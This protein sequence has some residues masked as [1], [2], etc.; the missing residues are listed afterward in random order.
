[1]PPWPSLTRQ[2]LAHDKLQKLHELEALCWVMFL[3]ALCKQAG[4]LSCTAYFAA[5]PSMRKMLQNL[6][7]PDFAAFQSTSKVETVLSIGPAA[8]VSTVPALK[9]RYAQ[10]LKAALFTGVHRCTQ[11]Q[12]RGA[13]PWHHSSCN[14]RWKQLRP[15]SCFWTCSC[16]TTLLCKRHVSEA[17]LLLP[18]RTFLAHLQA[19][20]RP[21]RLSFPADMPGS[22][23]MIR[24]PWRDSVLRTH[25]QALMVG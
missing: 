17:A 4:R 8:A 3:P 5:C 13:L 6:Q 7:K 24:S 19:R 14:R 2:R 20:I 15:T 18:I 21:L 9:V 16:S 22:P 23:L 25:M 11:A 12:L 10:Q 1:M